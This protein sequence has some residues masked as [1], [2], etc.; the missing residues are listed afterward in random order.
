[1]V[2]LEQIQHSMGL[3]LMAAA[4]EHGVRQQAAALAVLVEVTVLNQHHLE[5]DQLLKE[6]QAAQ[7]VMEVL[8]ALAVMETAAEQAVAEQVQQVQMQLL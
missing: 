8:V 2:L 4:T 7:L 3:H 1:M 6:T 5:Q